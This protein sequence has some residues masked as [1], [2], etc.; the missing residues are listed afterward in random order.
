MVE[1]WKRMESN[2]YICKNDI[3]PVIPYL[4]SFVYGEI[5]E[6]SHGSCHCLCVSASQEGNQH[7][8][9]TNTDYSLLVLIWVCVCVC[10]CVC[11]W[12]GGGGWHSL[13]IQTTKLEELGVFPS[14]AQ[15]FL[16]KNAACMHGAWEQDCVDYHVL[17]SFKKKQVFYWA[18]L[19][20]KC[21]DIP[22]KSTLT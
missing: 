1:H 12:G 19:V 10:V 7:W 11:V 18:L 8:K 13:L 4:I 3:T 5:S 21:F 6:G 17:C 20:F 15:H 16:L 2:V 22:L 14:F 9:T